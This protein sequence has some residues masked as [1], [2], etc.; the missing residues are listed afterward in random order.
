MRKKYLFF[1][2][3][4]LTLILI[5]GCKDKSADTP[6]IPEL[7]KYTVTFETDGGSTVDEQ[8][9]EKG[10]KVEKPQNPE[11]DGFYFVEWK[12]EDGTVWSFDTPV[13]RDITLT[14]VWSDIK[15]TVRFYSDG[16]LIKEVSVGKG[17]TVDPVTPEKREGY[18][19]DSWLK[20]TGTYVFTTPVTEDIA[21]EAKWVKQHNVDFMNDGTLYKTFTVDENTTVPKFADPEK[22]EW[23]F[24]GWFNGAV[25]FSF[26]QPVTSD[27]VLEAKWSQ[28]KIL[29]SFDTA[30]S[31][32]YNQS[33]QFVVK[34]RRVVQPKPDPVARTEGLTFKYWAL[35]DN[36]DKEFD[37]STAVTD[38]I[39]LVPV[40]E[41]TSYKVTITS[42]Y[43]YGVQDQT[44]KHGEKAVRPEP[45]PER[46]KYNFIGWYIEDTDTPFD[47]DTPITSDITIIGRWEGKEMKVSF[48][49]N[50]G[51]SDVIKTVKVKY[52]TNMSA[53]DVPNSP[54][55]P[56]TDTASYAFL[57]WS[58]DDSTLIRD[59]SSVKITGETTIKAEWM[60]YI[61]DSN[62]V[63]ITGVTCD[64]NDWITSLDIPSTVN[65]SNVVVIE[66]DAFIGLS[67]VTS[68]NIPETV[69]Q[70]GDFSFRYNSI[71]TLTLPPNLLLIGKYAFADCGNLESVDCKSSRLVNIA[72]FAFH[73][74]ANLKTF[75][76][77]TSNTN[78][79]SLGKG[80]F[81][82]TGLV[83]FG[84]ITDSVM[85]TSK[86]TNI[87]AN[88]F[89]NCN[90]K[91]FVVESGHTAFETD[92]NGSVLYHKGSSYYVMQVAQQ[93]TGKITISS[94]VNYVDSYEYPFRNCSE[95]TEVVLP[96]TY[97]TIVDYTFSG[98]TSLQ[99]INLS[100]VTKVGQRAFE[101]C[102][103]LTSLDFSSVTD[104]GEY[105]TF[106]ASGLKEIKVNWTSGASRH[107]G[108]N[109]L[110]DAYG[111]TSL[112]VHKSV[113]KYK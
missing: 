15:Y 8:K 99:S 30:T 110:W 25:E 26:T 50:D 81:L 3:L 113:Y 54:T 88:S 35:K 95:I 42:G 9:V 29:V 80:V 19:F 56:D 101:Y 76:Y 4:L 112:N 92:S 60:N 41:K 66:N 21:L 68:V 104:M 14:A 31:C 46:E 93:A 96:S 5:T 74:C 87:T 84:N 1:S 11:K 43:G 7:I 40:F 73:N 6:E 55:R 52:D 2:V 83:Q 45:V 57:G 47:F 97:K 37:F 109:E 67:S 79:S 10:A 62:S 65:G 16:S 105:V 48:V 91:K 39:T 69:I 33:P 27:L 85:I 100:H 63:A 13:T 86:L 111:D 22:E 90:I 102:S 71:K 72:E 70:I 20:G 61:Y 17:G 53:S 23:G 108:W 106:F 77:D 18:R 78:L 103:S 51:T 58:I 24:V 59:F 107:S 38:A 32:G 64:N 28:E 36:E 75:K 34:G 12:D 49:M 98:C 94:S 44:V 89:A 82:N